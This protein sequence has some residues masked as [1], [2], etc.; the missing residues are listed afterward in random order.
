MRVAIYTRVSTEDQAREGYSLE[1]QEEYLREYAKRE[2]W[3]IYRMYKDDG[4]S[5]YTKDRP[6]LKRL[7][8]DAKDRKFELILVY[9]IDRFSRNLMDLLNLVDELSTYEV[10]FKSATEFFDTTNSAGK[11][12]FQQL[13]SFAEF[14]RNRIKERVFPGMIKGAKN[15][16]WQGA[17][18][19]PYGYHYNK[20]KKLLEIIPEE[21]EIV[22]TIY[23]MYLTGNTTSEITAYLYRRG[24][25]TRTGIRFHSKLVYDILKNKVYTGKLI[26]NRRHYSK[27]EKTQGGYGKGYRYLPGQATDVVE[28]QGRHAPILSEDDFNRTQLRLANNRRPSHSIFN[29][30]E[31][32]LSGII[33]CGICGSRYLGSTCASNH[34]TKER[35]KW[36]RCRLRQETKGIECNNAS[37]VAAS[38][39]NFALDV[40]GKISTSKIV[41]EKRYADLL[42]TVLDSTDEII[43]QINSVEQSLKE[44]QEKQKKLTSIYLR[45]DIGQEVYMQS[46]EPLKIEEDKL[47]KQKQA[48]DMKLIEKEDSREYNN[49][50]DS[51]LGNFPRVKGKLS[52][53]EKKALLR[54]VFRKIIVKEGVVTEVDLYDPFKAVVSEGELRCLI[55]EI[56]PRIRQRNPVCTYARSDGRWPRYRGTMEKVA[57]ALV[58]LD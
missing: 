15:G 41:R 51:V 5:G 36:Y 13:G 32:L 52:I 21:A 48:L 34:R 49:L 39:D 3:H 24:Y 43:A 1:V 30:H 11:M 42:K 9:K 47:K 18:F 20:E 10:G 57:Q 6:E 54:L 55:R 4:I 23:T 33:R 31:H 27:K 16:N 2:K 46:Q 19:A 44:N 56:K 40:L 26:W 22:K 58:V 29:K 7:L 38:Y 14:E 25:R 37:I 35:K 28:V 45:E 50:L 17:R 8:A 53:S 12:M